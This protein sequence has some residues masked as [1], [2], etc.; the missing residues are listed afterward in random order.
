MVPLFIFGECGFV[1]NYVGLECLDV[2]LDI[3]II[4]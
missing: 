4:I 3:L 1:V 2:P